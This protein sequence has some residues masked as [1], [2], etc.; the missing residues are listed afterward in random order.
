MD[1]HVMNRCSRLFDLVLNRVAIVNQLHGCRY[2]HNPENPMRVSRDH[3]TYVV[4]YCDAEV[5]SFRS[6]DLDSVSSAFA[7]LDAWSRCVWLLSR[8]RRL[9]RDVV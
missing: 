8:A 9:V 3:G 1:V 4:T 6:N 5:V 2:D 7:V